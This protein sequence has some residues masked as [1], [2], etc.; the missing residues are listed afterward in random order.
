LVRNSA[1]SN[2]AELFREARRRLPEEDTLLAL[3]GVVGAYPNAFYT[4]DLA[5]LANFTDAVARLEQEEDL[6]ALTDRFGV[7]R[8]D[9]RF[10][11]LSDAIH[12]EWRRSAGQEAAI[13]DYSRF[14]NR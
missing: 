3:D 6:V 11:P 4:V 14:E 12:A 8:T 10:W 2:V 1:H 13:L 5:E 9:L 7:R